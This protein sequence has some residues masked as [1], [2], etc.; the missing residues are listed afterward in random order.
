MIQNTIIAELV[1]QMRAIVGEAFV[2]NDEESMDN[3][4]HDETEDFRFMPDIV[5]KAHTPEEISGITRLC[6]KYNVPLTPRGAGTGLCRG[7]LP[8]NA[9]V[10]LSMGRFNRIIS[11][12]E[13]N[14]QAT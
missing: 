14:F 9:G 7:A 6:N 12:D 3:C 2:F 11:I 5:V 13:K 10:V 1:V 4:S 8:V